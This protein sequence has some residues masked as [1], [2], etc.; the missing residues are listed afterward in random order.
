MPDDD[1]LALIT[2]VV[3]T[4]SLDLKVPRAA[5]EPVAAD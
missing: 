5:K 4:K 3:E 1:F 2:P